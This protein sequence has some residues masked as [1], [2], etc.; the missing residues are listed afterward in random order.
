MKYTEVIVMEHKQLQDLKR[1]HSL[2]K[3]CICVQMWKPKVLFQSSS[4]HVGH[5][6][7]SVTAIFGLAAP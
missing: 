4:S 5:Q 3:V 6:C 1:F 2:M 7:Y